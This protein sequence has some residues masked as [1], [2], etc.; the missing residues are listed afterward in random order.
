MTCRS[1]SLIAAL[2]LLAAFASPARAQ[3]AAGM[4]GGGCM[5]QQLTQLCPDAK[6]GTPDFSACSKLHS[7]EALATC[8]KTSSDA[9]AASTKKQV[10]ASSPC[11]DD[12]QKYC[13][14]KWPGTPEFSS[15]MRSHE[16]DL[17][18]ACA[19]WA[20][21]HSSVKGKPGDTTCVADAK[22]YCPGLTVMDG[23]KFNG[24]MVKNYDSLSPTCQ[25][26]YKGAKTAFASHDE[27]MAGLQKLCPG[28]QPEDHGAMMQCMMGHSSELPP[29]CHKH[30]KSGA[31]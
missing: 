20:K 14:G 10:S 24:C 2:A 18:P 16:S 6:P 26:L 19:A 27:C 13:P 21:N 9:A 1:L 25:A 3:D 29:S 12:V 7:G 4:M 28:L 31:K 30:G 22:K 5:M 15:C 11:A 8:Q 17:T 23:P